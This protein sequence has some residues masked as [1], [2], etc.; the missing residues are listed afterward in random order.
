MLV[1][2]ENDRALPRWLE[3]SQWSGVLG[4]LDRENRASLLSLVIDPTRLRAVHP[5]DVR[6][7]DERVAAR[8]GPAIVLGARNGHAGAH[9]IAGPE[10]RAEVGLVRDPQW[11]DNQVIPARVLKGTALQ[12]QV[13]LPRL[14]ARRHPIDRVNLQ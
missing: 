10:Q 4:Q 12:L 2:E 6:S 8:E 14:R 1:T 3:P 5:V 11:R 9:C 7:L 13:P